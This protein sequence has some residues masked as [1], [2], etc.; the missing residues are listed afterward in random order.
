MEQTQVVANLVGEGSVQ[1]SAGF[2]RA[3]RADDVVEQ[4]DPVAHIAGGTGVGKALDAA[5]GIVAV[6]FGTTNTLR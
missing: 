3:F 5:T 6:D 4:G 1:G 2:Q